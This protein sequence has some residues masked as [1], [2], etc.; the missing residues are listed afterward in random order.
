MPTTLPRALLAVVLTLLA[1]SARAADIAVE[2]VTGGLEHPWALAFLPDGAIL[3]TE[4]PG[5]LRLIVDGRLD[6]VPVAGLPQIVA[7]GQGGLL[8][9]AL[10]PGHAGNGLVYLTY[11]EPGEGGTAGTALARARLVR[12]G[13]GARLADVAVLFRQTPKRDSGVHFGAR[14]VPTA[15]GHLFVT[16]GERGDRDEAQ[17][18]DS[19]LGKVIRLRAD[20]TVPPDNPF[21]SLEGALPEIWS[22]GHRNPQGAALDPRDGRLWTVEH[23]ARGGDE[24]NRPQ[25]GANHGW[26]VTTHG[27]DYSGAPIGVGP[28]APGV[29]PPL[30]WWTPSIAPSGMAFYQG[31]LFPDW[32]GDLFIGALAGQ[33]LVRLDLDASGAIIGEQ[34]LLE[35]ALGRIRDVR[36]GPDG[37]LWLLTDDADGALFR[38]RPSGAG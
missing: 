7:D 11:A 30:H 18:L 34:R 29:A 21:V 26:P 28:T 3:V 19:H 33:M 16:L 20:G 15:D 5:R 37:A 1:S 9:L 2:R 22:Y 31:N 24:I 25:A 17:A 6:P 32:Q 38:I 35:G 13:D 10:D 14:V 8:D 23:G 4:R 27:V 36:S 12:D